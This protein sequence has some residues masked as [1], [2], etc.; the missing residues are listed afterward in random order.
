MHKLKIPAATPNP[1]WAKPN[2]E[3]IA[4]F[5]AAIQ[6]GTPEEKK[7]AQREQQQL[8]Q[9]RM[10]ELRGWWM[11]RM[12]RGPR[13]STMRRSTNCGRCS[14]RVGRPT[15]QSRDRKLACGACIHRRF[16][17]LNPII[18]KELPPCLALPP[19]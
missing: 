11:Q 4:R 18:F 5:R 2:P 9:Q 10:M 7:N 3:E 14:A 13:H 1:D 15:N 6:N 17:T 19:T 16:R 12:A 8:F